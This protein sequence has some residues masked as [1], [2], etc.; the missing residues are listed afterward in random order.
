MIE[1]LKSAI[2]RARNVTGVF[3]GTTIIN[4]PIN[5]AEEAHE[6]LL[7]IDILADFAEAA[8]ES[9]GLPEEIETVYKDRFIAE[10]VG[11]TKGYNASLNAC[12]PTFALLTAELAEAKKDLDRE[13]ANNMLLRRG[14]KI[15]YQKENCACTWNENDDLTEL[16]QAHK[17]YYDVENEKLKAENKHLH[18][19]LDSLNASLDKQKL[20]DM[21]VENARLA[22][23]EKRA[24]GITE[25][26]IEHILTFTAPDKCAAAVLALV[27]E[28]KTVAEVL[29]KLEG[30]GPEK[31]ERYE[32]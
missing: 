28:C 32:I 21:G 2:K 5:A 27:R 26:D 20:E 22:A 16:C 3:K 15:Q 23:F 9:G 29:A 7:A 30:T 17:N 13:S 11:Y 6:D 19:C 24:R 12:L 18:E 4:Y 1:K 25:S 14:E 31:E 10:D 8:V